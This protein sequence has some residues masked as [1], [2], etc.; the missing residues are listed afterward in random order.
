MEKIWLCFLL[1]INLSRK[2]GLEPSV[3][4]SVW[5]QHLHSEIAAL[6]DQKKPKWVQIRHRIINL[7]CFLPTNYTN[8]RLTLQ[9]LIQDRYAALRTCCYCHMVKI[10]FSAI[11]VRIFQRDIPYSSPF[12]LGIFPPKLILTRSSYQKW[13]TVFAKRRK[14]VYKG[15]L[16]LNCSNNNLFKWI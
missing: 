16:K 1:L 3:T 12:G 15:Q 2:N 10:W 11:W 8:S 14:N 5:G 7:L 9:A 4:C 6:K 13:N